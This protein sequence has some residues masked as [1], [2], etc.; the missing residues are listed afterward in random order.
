MRARRP[1]GRRVSGGVVKQHAADLAARGARVHGYL[2]DVHGTVHDVGDQ[3]RDRDTG[4][5]HRDPG[6][7]IPLVAGEFVHGERLIA[8]DLRHADLAEPA[9]SSASDS[10]ANALESSSSPQNNSTYFTPALRPP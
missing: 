4:V 6:A 3:V 10:A 1:L 2:L 9:L 7:V 5:I 8:G